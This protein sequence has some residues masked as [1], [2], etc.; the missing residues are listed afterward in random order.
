MRVPVYLCVRARAWLVYTYTFG[1]PQIVSDVR[2]F[3]LLVHTHTHTHTNNNN[4][5]QQWGDA[6]HKCVEGIRMLTV[7]MYPKIFG[8]H[9]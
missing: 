1:Y 2:S 3:L 7:T 8:R 9:A 5:K 6:W 4:N